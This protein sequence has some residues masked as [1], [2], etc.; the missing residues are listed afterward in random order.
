MDPTLGEVVSILFLEVS[1][2]CWAPL[3][4][5]QWRDAPAG[6]E[7]SRLSWALKH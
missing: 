3:Q 5:Q 1:N 2:S 6:E 4:L 7:A